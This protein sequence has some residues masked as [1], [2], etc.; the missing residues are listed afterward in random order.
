MKLELAVRTSGK[1]TT[2][3]D[4]FRDW[5]AYWYSRIK[6]FVTKEK[7]ILSDEYW[8]RTNKMAGTNIQSSR[9][10]SML[11]VKDRK[12]DDGSIEVKAYLHGSKRNLGIAYTQEYDYEQVPKRSRLLTIPNW[13][14]GV[15]QHARAKNFP[16]AKWARIGGHP[17][18]VQYNKQSKKNEFLFLG[19]ERVFLPAR[20]FWRNTVDA[21]IT[22][23]RKQLPQFL[24]LKRV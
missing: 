12:L 15:W 9:I 19:V 21:S 5:D 11:K 17:F 6:A 2:I 14:K 13:K 7:E 10:S 22:K 18:L 20:R 8:K 16:R 3:N 1:P 23:I 24:K 4:Y